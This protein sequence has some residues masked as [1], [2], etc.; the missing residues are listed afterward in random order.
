MVVVVVDAGRVV[1]V[2]AGLPPPSLPVP[3]PL[4]EE[5]PQS[6]GLVTQSAPPL[7]TAWMLPP[8]TNTP[9][10]SSKAMIAT[11]TA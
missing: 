6:L 2:A 3:L 11:I 8:S 1:V 5:S 10:T 7:N 9:P 4:P